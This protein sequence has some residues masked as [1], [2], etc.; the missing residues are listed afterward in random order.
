MYENKLR[1]CALNLD[2]AA[3]NVEKWKKINK[4]LD[5]NLH[6]ENE[7]FQNCLKKLEHKEKELENCLSSEEKMR[8]S[9]ELETCRDEL[10]KCVSRKKKFE[11]KRDK[12]QL[13][14]E[15]LSEQLK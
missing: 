10:K 1:E 4:Q 15:T 5:D 11:E 14:I 12:H 7:S 2:Y 13:E 9:N 8:L 3:Q 6:E